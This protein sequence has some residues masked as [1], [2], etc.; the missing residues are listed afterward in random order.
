M[1]IPIVS[2]L[3]CVLVLGCAS[4]VHWA[5]EGKTE[6]ETERDYRDCVDQT[7]KRYGTIVESPH[8]T[9][10]LNQCMESKGYKRKEN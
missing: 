1:K 10:D 6:A 2:L 9:T 3:L 4:Q 8:F 7:Q 5:Q